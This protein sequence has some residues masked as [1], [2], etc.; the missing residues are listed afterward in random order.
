MS[1]ILPLFEIGPFLE[2]PQNVLQ[3]T[4]KVTPV[5]LAELLED[6]LK[7]EIVFKQERG[8]TEWL[9]IN[10]PDGDRTVEHILAGHLN[11]SGNGS[12]LVSDP[13]PAPTGSPDPIDV[14]ALGDQLKTDLWR[15]VHTYIPAPLIPG[16]IY[17]EQAENLPGLTGQSARLIF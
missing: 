14:N 12:I 11:G 9:A 8:T 1:K 16:V 15:F 5:Q 13:T 2:D 3:V 4:P 6:A 7:K 10:Y 17:P